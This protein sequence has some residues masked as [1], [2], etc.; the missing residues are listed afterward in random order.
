M[1]PQGELAQFHNG[2]EG[3]RYIA[4]AEL[5]VDT[6]RGNHYHGIKE[7]FVYLVQGEVL[8]VVEDIESKEQES[9]RLES[10][11]LVFIS[12]RIA[13]AFRPLKHGRAIEFSKTRFDAAD[14]QR[15]KVL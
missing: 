14:V 2:D 9:A 5:V 8:L 1:L 6:I 3:I 12:T 4:Y 15:F 10:G 13:H 7:E 11:D